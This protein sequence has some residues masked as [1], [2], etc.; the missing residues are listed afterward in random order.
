MHTGKGRLRAFEEFRGWQGRTTNPMV[1]REKASARQPGI[2][3]RCERGDL[4]ASAAGK[5]GVRETTSGVE[6]ANGTLP[7]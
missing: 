5:V 7:F 3:G 1:Q 2:G 4:G 6:T